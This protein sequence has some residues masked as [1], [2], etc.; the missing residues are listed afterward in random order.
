MNTDRAAPNATTIRIHGLADMIFGKAANIRRIARQAIDD[1]RALTDKDYLD[2]LA[3]WGGIRSDS[4]EF[5]W[6]LRALRELQHKIDYFGQLVQDA[7]IGPYT[8]L[9]NSQEIRC[10]E[11]TVRLTR[12]EFAIVE[13][14]LGKQ[15][16][17]SCR[18]LAHATAGHKITETEARSLIRPHISNLRGKVRR[19][20]TIPII[21]SVHGQGYRLN[22]TL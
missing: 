16:V 11:A 10:D 8:L 17:V 15:R 12:S 18:E 4:I 14:L 21:V 20:C 5:D 13:Y 1:D 2:M 3:F 22:P 19:I 6:E 9:H 7:I